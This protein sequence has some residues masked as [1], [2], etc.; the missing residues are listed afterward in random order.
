MSDCLSALRMVER[1][2]REGVEWHGPRTGRAALLH[3]INAEREQ[4]EPVVMMWTPAH[5][6]VTANAYAD[7]AAK[8]PSRHGCTQRP[9]P[10]W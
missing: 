3:A 9:S 10:Q 5:A 7:A 4:L 6:G 2:W 1:A 8:G